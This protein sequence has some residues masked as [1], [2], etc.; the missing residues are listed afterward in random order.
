MRCD[1]R[2]QLAISAL[3]LLLPGFWSPSTVLAQSAQNLN[4]RITLTPP[5]G[6]GPQQMEPLKAHVTDPA[7]E[8]GADFVECRVALFSFVAGQWFPQPFLTEQ[9]IEIDPNGLVDE[10]IHLGT[11]YAALLVYR[12]RYPNQANQIS[13]L[14]TRFALAGD[15]AK[16]GTRNEA[17]PPTRVP[18]NKIESNDPAVPVSNRP[19][20]PSLTQLQSPAVDFVNPWIL[21]VVLGL[22]LLS[23]LLNLTD[24]VE[25]FAKAFESFFREL[26]SAPYL[27]LCRFREASARKLAEEVPCEP[28]RAIAGIGF[29]AIVIGAAVANYGVVKFSLEA[30]LPDTHALS[31]LV[32][33]F[34]CSKAGAG[35]LSHLAFQHLPKN[36]LAIL[37]LAVAFIFF[38]LTCLLDT[39]ITYK[40]V[41]LI[42]AANIETLSTSNIPIRF[43]ENAMFMAGL[44]LLMSCLEFV[45]AC[46][47]FH[48]ASKPISWLVFSPVLVPAYVLELLLGVIHRS[49]VFGVL[50]TLLSATLIAP[51]VIA[52][53]AIEIARWFLRSIKE[54]AKRMGTSAIAWFRQR[55]VRK[56]QLDGEAE[57]VH[58]RQ[59]DETAEVIHTTKINDARRAAMLKQQQDEIQF[60]AQELAATLNKRREVNSVLRDT[61]F[62]VASQNIEKMAEVFP[63]T[64]ASF[65]DKAEI[66]TQTSTDSQVEQVAE[67]M[68]MAAVRP[69]LSMS[70]AQSSIDGH[71]PQIKYDPNEVRGYR[72]KV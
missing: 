9:L 2:R 33:I 53:R 32:L 54:S 17:P 50:A 51:K 31:V 30:F 46:A 72:H 6:E 49:N 45:F 61:V 58:H 48:L 20:D 18:A 5:S 15:E 8:C 52:V 69:I 26:I 64:F 56:A 40:R 25:P 62:I 14:P 59:S 19:A 35:W 70:Y 63:R 37:V 11:R 13:R 39:G 42:E 44:T 23:L 3:I 24:K 41:T 34:V 57:R 29:F 27:A 12:D 4:I 47:A 65:V 22:F 28:S 43:S 38:A 36:K 55:K 10:D 7:G 1:P 68:T 67:A 60:G 71:Y 16:A 66:Q 21:Q